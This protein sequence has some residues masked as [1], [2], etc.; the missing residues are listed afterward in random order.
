MVS[1][2]IAQAFQAYHQG[3]WVEAEW[4]CQDIVQQQPGSVAAWH[5]LGAIA[6]QTQRLE[7]AHDYYRQVIQL[8]PT[9]AEAHA[10]LAVVLQ[11]QGD[12]E[13]AAAEFQ[14]ALGL[15]PHHAPAQFNYANL[16]AEQ[17]QF[18]AAI[19]HYRQAIALKPD[20]AKAYNNLGNA[21]GAVGDRAAAIAAFEQAI[22]L[23][24]NLAEACNNLGNLFQEQG[25]LETAISWYEQFLTL[26]PTDVGGYYN[27][28]NALRELLH[29][30]GAIA[31]YQNALKLQPN[32]ADI[33]NNL[34]IA[35]QQAGRFDAAI[36]Q[37]QQAIDL[38]PDNSEMHSNL[39]I[40]L[41]EYNN[42]DAAIHHY[43]QAIRLNPSFAEA[44]ANLGMMLLATGD[45]QQ[46]FAEYEWRCYCDNN[47]PRFLPK[48]QWHGSDLRG[49]TILIYTT[50][51]G[52][53]DALQFIRFV[54]QLAQQGDRIIVECQESLIRLFQTLPEIAQIVPKGS[55]LP[56][57]D[58]HI[59]LM[60][61]P[62][63]LGT[64]LENLPATVPY[65]FP[66]ELDN[67][68]ELPP[69]PGLR[70][71][72]VW[73]PGYRSALKL[74][75]LYQVRS[76]SL[77]LWMPLSALPELSLFSLQIGAH[78]ADIAQ[79]GMEQNIVDLSPQIRD[80]ADTAALIAQLDL[81]IS[82]DTAVAHLAGAL[83]K[84]VWVLLPYAAD[85][86]WM[87]D[88][89]DSP[90]YP[91]VRLFRQAAPGDWQSVMNQVLQ[92]LSEWV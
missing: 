52:F 42:P 5:L 31:A 73:A 75:R 35:Y 6:A 76:C 48:P 72:I 33:H 9:H 21:L 1:P 77:P 34:G 45:F 65:L 49:K 15:N 32:V 11:R 54:P 89:Q 67:L 66:A 37:F 7:S 78:A 2:A 83:G 57:F 10:N 26:R 79:A 71:G 51:Q 25:Q 30:D 29:L 64:T 90:W 19:A 18:P 4:R 86:R 3:N 13:T 70:V 91:T 46:G 23:D 8:D 84:P 28:G 60:S 58:F 92:A 40:A 61:L 39:G 53:G 55:V 22:Q 87:L 43:R 74:F 82:V 20:Y 63:V 17:G 68:P 56:E 14:Q 41:Q 62:H 69:A 24:P 44:H 47:Q 81:V 80:F 12:L 16:L 36:A 59:S 88:R 50:E 38:Q 85:W 27:L